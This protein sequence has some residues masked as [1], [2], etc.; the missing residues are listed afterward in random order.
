[1]RGKKARELRQAIRESKIAFMS[2]GK[3]KSRVE[4]LEL[5]LCIK[6]KRKWWQ[7]WI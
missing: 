2:Y 5:K 3:L 4:Y 7:I 1:M 6:P